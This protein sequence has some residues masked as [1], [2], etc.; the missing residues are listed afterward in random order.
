MGTDGGAEAASA[1]Q[2]VFAAGCGG[3][4]AKAAGDG[5]DATT[6]QHGPITRLEATTRGIHSA[7][8]DHSGRLPSIAYRSV[9]VL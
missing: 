6:H 7:E 2:P 3:W 9:L 4:V 1:A 8:I 5:A